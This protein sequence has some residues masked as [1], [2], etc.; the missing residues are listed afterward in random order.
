MLQWITDNQELLIALFGAGGVGAILL[1]RLVGSRKATD[2]EKK[3][4][5]TPSIKSTASERG[6]A[7]AHAGHGDVHIGVNRALDEQTIRSAK[8][9]LSLSLQETAR[10]LKLCDAAGLSLEDFD[11]LL[12]RLGSGGAG[13]DRE[14]LA[15]AVRAGQDNEANA[16]VLRLLGRGPAAPTGSG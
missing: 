1:A 7:V 13:G 2:Q 3:T 10:L 15:N 5:P 9:K 6:V 4:T 12:A 8:Q 16:I 11:L 14:A